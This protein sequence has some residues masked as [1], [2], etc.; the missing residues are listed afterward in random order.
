[1]WTWIKSVFARLTPVVRFTLITLFACFIVFALAIRALP[2]GKELYLAVALDPV[3]VVS[4]GRVWTL[5]TYALVHDLTNTW[6]LLFNCMVFY[7]FGSTMESRWGSKR[8]L[9]FMVL[10]A[11]GGGLFVLAANL[12]GLGHSMVIGA[13]AVA[14]GLVIA[15]GLAYP[16]R[17]I[18][19][20]F[21]PVKALHLVY[22]TIALEVLNT[23]SLSP[24]SAAAHWGGM[25]TGYLL[26]DSSPV[27][28]VFLK[29]R[30]R[31]LEA[32]AA[33]I[34]LRSMRAASRRA[35]PPL[36]VIPGGQKDPPKDKRFLN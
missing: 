6:H 19:L 26:C 14:I 32:Q 25:F 29:Y 11:I 33:S 12:I 21:F 31:R 34:G 9:V 35:G 17:E 7:F 4:E 15:F 24:V 20:F 16:D 23:V 28:R 1:M 2:F 8:L 27:R 3:A 5:L 36:R 10:T 18:L 30:L 22:I 13:S